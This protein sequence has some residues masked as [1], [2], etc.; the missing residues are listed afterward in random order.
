MHVRVGLPVGDRPP[1]REG[2]RV[3]VEPQ[4]VAAVREVAA[5]QV[6]VGLDLDE[7]EEAAQVDGHLLTQGAVPQAGAGVA[8]SLL[9]E[10]NHLAIVYDG[11]P[12]RLGIDV[13]LAARVGRI[14][15]LLQRPADPHARHRL[16]IT[17]VAVEERLARMMNADR[18]FHRLDPL[19]RTPDRSRLQQDL[20]ACGALV[21][22]LGVGVGKGAREEESRTRGIRLHMA[23][24][25]RQQQV[26]RL[27]ARGRKAY[28][29]PEAPDQDDE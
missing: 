17:V 15:V 4:P 8:V 22:A 28:A 14:T 9:V 3:P 1:P 19:R 29:V 13:A 16:I 2:L 24:V 11:H 20:A 10:G 7:N 6:D 23:L 21:R 26:K 27:F 12:V 25:G 5:A 18:R